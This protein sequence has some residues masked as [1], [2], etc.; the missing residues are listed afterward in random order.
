MPPFLTCTYMSLIYKGYFKNNCCKNGK[1]GLYKYIKRW[2]EWAQSMGA[3]CRGGGEEEGWESPD[4]SG[5]TVSAMVLG[6]KGERVTLGGRKAIYFDSW[7]QTACTGV[8]SKPTCPSCPSSIP[9]LQTSDVLLKQQPLSCTSLLPNIF[10]KTVTAYD[11]FYDL[12]LWTMTLQN[13]F[14]EHFRQHCS[15]GG[16][17]AGWQQHLTSQC[18]GLILSHTNSFC[19]SIEVRCILHL[20][21]ICSA[22]MLIWCSVPNAV[23]LSCY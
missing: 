6:L 22:R 10:K 3:I 7:V 13:L 5:C 21:S 11:L 23:Y 8:V 16:W 14:H 9:A 4:F 17:R 12:E 18:L 19:S 2:R 1:C 20:C 15:S